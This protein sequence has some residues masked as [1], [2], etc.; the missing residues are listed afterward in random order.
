M[1]NQV[2]AGI[3]ITA[4]IL[5][6]FVLIYAHRSARSPVPTTRPGIKKSS[7]DM[8]KD[9]PQHPGISAVKGRKHVPSPKESKHRTVSGHIHRKVSALINDLANPELSKV[10]RNRIEHMLGSNQDKRIAKEIGM[11]LED[12]LLDLSEQSRTGMARLMSAVRIAGLRS[13]TK[14]VEGIIN[15]C[16]HPEADEEVR[17]AGYEALG[18]MGT[19]NARGFLRKELSFGQSGFLQSQIVLSLGTAGDTE[20]SG[21][22]LSYL[23]RP[24]PDLRDSAIIAL[25]RI[26]EARA[27]LEF[28][29][30]YKNTTGSSRVLIV[31]ALKDIGSSDATDLLNEISKETIN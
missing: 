21:Q 13:D 27:V 26:K 2:K 22:F 23:N 3:V 11:M 12:G 7:V 8:R 19:K 5:L 31:Q 9:M 14:S 1:N 18:Y 16:T 10:E 24:D 17:M 20:S 29:E 6:A 28:K 25:G 15:I 30:I 4:I